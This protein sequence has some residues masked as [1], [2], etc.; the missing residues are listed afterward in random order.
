MKLYFLEIQFVHKH[1]QENIFFLSFILLQPRVLEEG[2]VADPKLQWPQRDFYL[3]SK[4]GGGGGSDHF[5]Y[6]LL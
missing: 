4:T 3:K 1:F 2:V 6:M 5:N